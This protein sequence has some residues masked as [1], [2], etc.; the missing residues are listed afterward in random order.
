MD[1][2]ARIRQFN[3]TLTQH[4]GVLETNFLGRGRPLG[5]SRI[6]FEIGLESSEVR[7][8]RSKLGLDSGYT[9]RLLR[10]LE[11]EGLVKVQPSSEDARV[12]SANLTP[13][14][15]RELATLNRLS[16]EAAASTLEPLTDKQ[17]A[18]LIQNMEVVETLLRASGVTIEIQD[19]TSRMAQ[20]CIAN[21]YHELT[22]RF[23]N[24]F[25]PDI[26]MSATSQE[27]TP[28]NGY[29]VVAELYGNG[30]GCGALKCHKHFGE[31]KR[32]WVAS[33]TRGLG[34]GKRILARLETIARQQK[35]KVLRLETNKNLVEAQTLYRNSGYRE[36]APFN[37][38]PYAHYWFEK[39]L[40]SG[41]K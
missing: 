27:L 38:E 31:I 6:L 22:K 3:R 41:E 30:V 23:D 14:G 24:G 10:L 25:N 32:M 9:S 11:K 15:R 40:T 20:E 34:I 1:D 4:L 5:A 13:K 36:V 26:S 19:P 28:P 33:S 8:L 37:S 39:T 16:D 21:Y 7:D 18:T 12:R 2:I 17:K 35:L 29:F